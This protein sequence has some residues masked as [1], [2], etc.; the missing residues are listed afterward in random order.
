MPRTKWRTVSCADDS[1]RSHPSKDRAFDWV[2]EQTPGLVFRV[3]FDECRGGGWRD[4]ARVTA[5]KPGWAK[6]EV[7]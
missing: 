4:V 3:Q 6:E 7:A 2:A 1:L 5:V